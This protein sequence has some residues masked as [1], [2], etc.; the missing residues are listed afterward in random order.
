MGFSETIWVSGSE[1]S[2]I[3]NPGCPFSS[4]KQRFGGKKKNKEDETRVTRSDQVLRPKEGG[5]MPTKNTQKI[6]C[7]SRRGKCPGLPSSP[8]YRL[9]NSRIQMERTLKLR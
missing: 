4:V 1:Y 5:L 9:I 8:S 3:L 2:G 7:R 6:S